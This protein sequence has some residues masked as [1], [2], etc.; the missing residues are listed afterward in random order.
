MDQIP[1]RQLIRT[2]PIE[3]VKFKILFKLKCY[4]LS[5]SVFK[6]SISSLTNHTPVKM[7]AETDNVFD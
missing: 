4:S 2:R 3:T 7:S 6:T 1:E 5:P